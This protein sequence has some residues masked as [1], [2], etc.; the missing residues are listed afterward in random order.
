MLVFDREIQGNAVVSCDGYNDTGLM[1][2]DMFSYL[3]VIP[4]HGQTVLQEN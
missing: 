3:P 4:F 2:Y 1:P